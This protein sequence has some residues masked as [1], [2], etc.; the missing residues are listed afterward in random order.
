MN[1][2]ELLLYNT[3][4]I[5]NDDSYKSIFLKANCVPRVAEVMYFPHYGSYRVFDVI[6]H[7]TDDRGI[8]EENEIM[9][10]TIKLIKLK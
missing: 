4:N 8:N 5:L 6:Y 2:I 7:I 9:F 1:K 3:Y 10:V